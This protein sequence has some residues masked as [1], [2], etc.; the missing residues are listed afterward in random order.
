MDIKQIKKKDVLGAAFFIA[1]CEVV[2][3]LGAIF[4][5]PNI[6]TWYAGLDKPMIAP[7]NWIFGPV[8]TLLFALMGVAAYLVWKKRKID[9]RAEEA[10]MIFFVQLWLNVAWS[11]I[12]FGQHS[13]QGAFAEIVILWLAIAV[14]ILRFKPVSLTA[15]YLLLPYLLWVAFAGYLNF[16]IFTLN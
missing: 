1:I 9:T 16:L 11:V 4:T 3:G 12:F 7:P 14:T 10:L 8:W 15:A 5:M 2:G 13:L 6:G